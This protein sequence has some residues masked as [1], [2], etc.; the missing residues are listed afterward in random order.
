[1]KFRKSTLSI[2][3]IMTL[4]MSI[5]NSSFTFATDAFDYSAAVLRMKQLGILDSSVSNVTKVMTRGEFA[6]AVVI[7]DNL[8]DVASAV[9]GSTVFP[10]VASYSALSGYVNILLNKQLISGMADGKFHPEASITYSEI[11]TALVKLLGYADSDLKGTWPSNYLS[12]ASSLKITDNLGL[13][14]NDKVTIRNAAV[15]F[16]RLL[17]TNVKSGG[18]SGTNNASQVMFSDSIN[19]YS[20]C[21]IED[22]SESYSNLASDEVLTDK[23]VLHI[24]DNTS[25]LQVGTT[26][27]LK[28]EDGE[29]TKVYGKVKE[30]ETITVNSM[31]GSIIYY[32]EAGKEKNMTLPASISYY[33]H[34]EK[35]DYKSV[36]SLLLTNMSIIFDSSTNTAGNYAVITDPIYSKPQLASDFNPLSDKLGDITFDADTKII[37]NGKTIT[38]GQINDMDVVYSVTDINGNN[39]YVLV[40]ENYIEGNITAFLANAY[41]SNGIQIDKTSYNYSNDMDIAKLSSFTAGEL[42]AIILGYDGKVV[43]IKNIDHKAGSIGEYIILG[44]SKTSDNLADNEILTDKGTLTYMNDLG[45]LEVGSK[46][47]LY[48]NDRLITKINNKENSTENYVITEKTGLEMK[49]KNNNNEVNSMKLPKSTV[50]YYHGKNVNY[51]TAV[52]A[53]NAFSSIILSKG[54]SNEEYEYVVIVDPYFSVPKV[55]MR[56]DTE[57][58]NEIQNSKY[59]YVYR[60]E[61]YTMNPFNI[62]SYDVVYFV[63]D[64]WDKSCY[65]YV[66]NK[67]VYG[68]IDSFAPSKI[69]PS[70]IKV[71]GETYELSQYLD[72]TK[73]S[74]SYTGQ[75]IKLIIG[76][77]GKVV[78]VY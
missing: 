43:D 66:N 24:A 17:N 42:V 41:S 50:Y 68:F 71:N 15:M 72:K 44:N 55:F 40:V 54:N 64:I 48:V 1:M 46:Y 53:I 51:N 26:Y 2:F 33:Y 60:D 62:V 56:G 4:F 7:A 75:S 58:W 14:K 16:D 23:G 35:K 25:K 45:S 30:T 74:N 65:I 18:T 11:C 31:V 3:L 10:D 28:I 5:I 52:A 69:N 9:E 32:E 63:S 22:N 21:I 67:I 29:I 70:S 13:K 57:F 47:E 20:D 27:R 34:G 76:V 8:I 39:K 38:K 19:L 37:K 6:K 78:D 12:K 59:S 49:W 73:L 77:D 36:S 61:M